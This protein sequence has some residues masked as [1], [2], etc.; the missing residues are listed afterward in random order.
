MILLKSVDEELVL[1]HAERIRETMEK[2]CFEKAGQVTVSIGVVKIRPEETSDQAC[3]R[4]D[5]ALYEAK[6]TGKNRVVVKI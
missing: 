2:I 3:S 6:N 1:M 5:A 4:V